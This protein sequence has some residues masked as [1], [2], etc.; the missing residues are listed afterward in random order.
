MRSALKF[1]SSLISSRSCRFETSSTTMIFCLHLLAH[2]QTIQEEAR[3]SIR[4]IIVKHN[5]E[6]CY[7]AVMEM[8][9]L[10]Q[11]IEGEWSGVTQFT[12]KPIVIASQNASNPV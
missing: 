12:Y 6:W 3:E 11:I 2:H 8:N 7:E 10:E 5:G 1:L 4:K 9:F